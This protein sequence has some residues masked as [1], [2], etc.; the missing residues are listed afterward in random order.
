MA[1]SKKQNRKPVVR[2]IGERQYQRARSLG[3]SIPALHVFDDARDSE[4][5][6]LEQNNEQCDRDVRR[7]DRPEYQRRTEKIRTES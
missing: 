7:T 6:A 5:D 2:A 1:K 4:H 3:I